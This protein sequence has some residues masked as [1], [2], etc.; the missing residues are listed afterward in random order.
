MKLQYI[1][2]E[3]FKNIKHQGFNFDPKYH[4]E[5]NP[6][7]DDEGNIIKGQLNCRK[8]DYDLPDDFFGKE[9]Q[10]VTGIVGRNGSGKSNLLQFIMNWIGNHTVKQ[11]IIFKSGK[12]KIAIC[13]SKLNVASKELVIKE[14]AEDSFDNFKKL[15]AAVIYNSFGIRAIDKRSSEKF[16]NDAN[17]STSFFL[18]AISEREENDFTE[19]FNILS[20]YQWNELRM[21]AD[22]METNSFSNLKPMLGNTGLDW[23][24]IYPGYENFAILKI[25]EI[26][27]KSKIY[28]QVLMSSDGKPDGVSDKNFLVKLITFTLCGFVLKSKYDK[29]S[30]ENL[31]FSSEILSDLD[32]KVLEVLKSVK[33]KDSYSFNIDI[34]ITLIDKNVF[35]DFYS[36]I[37]EDSDIIDQTVIEFFETADRFDRILNIK[38]A[39]E[40]DSTFNKF[41]KDENQE[42]FISFIEFISL[43][44]DKDIKCNTLDSWLF[45]FE[46]RISK[47]ILKDFLDV[48]LATI[49]NNPFDKSHS[50]LNIQFQGL[51]GGELALL[52]TYARLNYAKDILQRNKT[53]EDDKK[54][55]GIELP[56][57]E[58]YLLLI[59][60]MELYLHPDWKKKYLS[61]LLK[62]LPDFFAKPVQ[63]IITSHSPFIVS[64]LPKE[65]IIFLD[66]Y[67]DKD[68][69]VINEKQK[70]GNCKVLDS[71]KK[72]KT[73]G[74]NIHTLLSDSFFMSEGLIG[75]FAEEKI[76]EI[77]T[78]FHRIKLEETQNKPSIEKFRQEYSNNIE[79]FKKTQNII[80]E[81][82]IANV[83]KNHINEIE[84]IFNK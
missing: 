6:E 43:I 3:K 7:F 22:F 10:N 72:E 14:Y 28:R 82:I 63:L 57:A 30:K 61:L 13:H 75:D 16:I 18:E 80:G 74:Q 81:P 40:F 20:A 69:E 12:E 48:Y 60:E 84:A 21:I 59:D 19:K 65:N 71:G 78:F 4:F 5:F 39:D 47:R 42:V 26:F 64:D 70:E 38:E 2:I 44:D 25:K 32:E 54:G 55:Y 34:I 50:Y 51:S 53:N 24:H 77:L 83:I 29:T 15:K 66:K 79:R 52:N 37:P 11:I 17:I 8:T 35:Q 56:E 1:W 9:I 76:N 45:T 58:A 31:S 41:L 36:C 33:S 62:S 73:F 68:T 49:S 67:K 46:F 23:I 27:R